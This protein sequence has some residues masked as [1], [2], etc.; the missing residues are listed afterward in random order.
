M[1][2]L[3]NNLPTVYSL[4]QPAFIVKEEFAKLEVAEVIAELT[5]I[6]PD[7]EIVLLA[8]TINVSLPV[9]NHVPQIMNVMMPT[10]VVVCVPMVFVKQ[11][12]F[13]VSLVQITMIALVL[14]LYAA[15]ANAHKDTHAVS[16]VQ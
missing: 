4:I 3:A 13:V 6:V 7:K 14:A 5:Q 10:L 16:V 1:V 11:E 15:V 2:L 8:L 12:T 9:V